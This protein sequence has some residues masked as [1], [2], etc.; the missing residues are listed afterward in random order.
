MFK[1]EKEKLS[2][3]KLNKQLLN[4]QQDVKQTTHHTP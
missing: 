4:V 2:N 1:I 3:W